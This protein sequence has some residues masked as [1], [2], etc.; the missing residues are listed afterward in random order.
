MNI[1]LDNMDHAIN[2]INGFEALSLRNF[3]DANAQ[4]A[5]TVLKMN[6]CDM[7]AIAGQEGFMTALKAGGKKLVEMIWELLKK[8]K[9]FFF[10][11]AGGKADK[12]IDQA[13]D[14]SKVAAKA[15][16]GAPNLA[17]KL[18]E[19]EGS[20]SAPIKVVGKIVNKQGVDVGLEKMIS[21]LGKS[22]D[23]IREATREYHGQSQNRLIKMNNML[24]RDFTSGI[25]QLISLQLSI[26]IDEGSVDGKI[27]IQSTTRANEINNCLRKIRDGAK[28]YLAEATPVLDELT[29]AHD[30]ALKAT[31]GA[32]DSGLTKA[33]KHGDQENAIKFEPAMRAIARSIAIAVR[34][35]QQCNDYIKETTKA[36]VKIA[37]LVNED[38]A[39]DSGNIINSI[40]DLDRF[41]TE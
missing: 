9:E 19:K 38:G 17:A 13:I 11:A 20:L 16:A 7:G 18:L 32:G 5:Q 15:V 33:M 34:L 2:M 35:I 3:G 28:S 30:R 8:I 12:T 25:S 31:V 6:D 24:T 40:E 14:I 26:V 39:P 10:G 29:Q 21:E 1:D 23:V 41:M 22:S 37:A 36:L 4:Y 27:L